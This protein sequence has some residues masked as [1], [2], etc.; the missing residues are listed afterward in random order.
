MRYTF[1]PA[2]NRN[3]VKTAG[4]PIPIAVFTAITESGPANLLLLLC[5]H[6]FQRIS[7]GSIPAVFYFDK[8]KISAVFG[9]N[10]NFPKTAVKILISDI[11]SR[12]DIRLPFVRIPR[13]PVCYFLPNPFP[14]LSAKL[15]TQPVH[16]VY[17]YQ[18]FR[19][20]VVKLRRYGIADFQFRKRMRQLVVFV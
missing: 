12:P 17:K 16:V 19:Y 10:I 5:S 18:D 15:R 1:S 2:C 8:Y 4:N 20:N 6:R 3:H 13:R 14:R 11:P 7:A 9:Y